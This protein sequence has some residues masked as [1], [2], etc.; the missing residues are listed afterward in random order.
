[1]SAGDPDAR[2]PHQWMAHP[3][4]DDVQ[5]GQDRLENEI[6]R[7]GTVRHREYRQIQRSGPRPGEQFV[8]V[9]V[10]LVDP[11]VRT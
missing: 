1:M 11:D 3:A 4:C 10:G 2:P 8:G 9:R 5:P 7:F 6:F